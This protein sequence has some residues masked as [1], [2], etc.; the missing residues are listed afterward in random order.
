MNLQF[1]TVEGEE[2]ALLETTGHF[3]I[4]EKIFKFA[5]TF[6]VAEFTKN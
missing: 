4:R 3:G 5:Q 6:L 2:K 1:Y